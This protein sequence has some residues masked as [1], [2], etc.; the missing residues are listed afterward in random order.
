MLLNRLTSDWGLPWR[1]S[2]QICSNVLPYEG[3]R[4][5]T[6][7]S[8]NGAGVYVKKLSRWIRLSRL[9]FVIVLFRFKEILA[10]LV[11]RSNTEKNTQRSEKKRVTVC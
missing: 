7:R 3:I 4:I 9:A 8:G 1:L 2:L 11:R 10:R 6:A 5:I